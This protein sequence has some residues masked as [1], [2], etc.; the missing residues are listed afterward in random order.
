[1]QWATSGSVYGMASR[2]RPQARRLR[3]PASRLRGLTAATCRQ[4]GID[5]AVAD[6]VSRPWTDVAIVPDFVW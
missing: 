4:V 3:R 2:G 1:M 6:S 5:A